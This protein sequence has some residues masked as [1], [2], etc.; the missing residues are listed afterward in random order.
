MKG[1]LFNLERIATEEK[2]KTKKPTPNITLNGEKLEAFAVRSGRR[3][4]CPLSPFLF[5]IIPEVLDHA[6]KQET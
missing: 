2:T 5:N 6:R 4:E 3:Q 1:T